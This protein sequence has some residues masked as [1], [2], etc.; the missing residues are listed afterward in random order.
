MEKVLL[1][2]GGE[3]PNTF[4]TLVRERGELLFDKRAKVLVKGT[5]TTAKIFNRTFL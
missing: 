2:L 1:D 4:G 5:L 3:L